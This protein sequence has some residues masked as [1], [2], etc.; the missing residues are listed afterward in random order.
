MLIIKIF[1]LS[2]VAA[3]AAAGFL[4][5]PEKVSA[6]TVAFSYYNGRQ[7]KPA[8]KMPTKKY[9]AKRSKKNRS[10]TDPT[11]ISSEDDVTCRSE[12]QDAKE[13]TTRAIASFVETPS[14]VK[15]PEK[16][17]FVQAATQCELTKRSSIAEQVRGE[18]AEFQLVTRAV[19]ATTVFSD[20]PESKEYVQPTKSF[21][22][23]FAEK[24]STIKPNAA[25]TFLS[26][27]D[28]T[29]TFIKRRPLVA[30][31]S[32]PTMT[33]TG[34]IRYD[35][36]QSPDQQ[37]VLSSASLFN[38]DANTKVVMFD[39]CT[40]F[41][42]DALSE[43]TA[44][45]AEEAA[46]RAAATLG[47]DACNKTSIECDACNKT[48]IVNSLCNDAVAAAEKVCLAN[49]APTPGPP[50][51]S[52]ICQFICGQNKGYLGA[53]T[54]V[55]TNVQ[56]KLSKFL[57]LIN[58]TILANLTQIN[59]DIVEVNTTLANLVTVA[60]TNVEL[61]KVRLE[62]ATEA[63]ANANAAETEAELQANADQAKLEVDKSTE[64]ADQSEES[65]A[66]T[67]EASDATAA[68]TATTAAAA[69][70]GVEAT[71]TALAI[72]ADAIAAAQFGLDPVSDALAVAA[73]AAEGVATGADTAANVAAA[74]ADATETAATSAQAASTTADAAADAATASA[75]AADD[76]AKGE[77]TTDDEA[78][79]KATE[80]ETKCK[81]A[82]T[83]AQTHQNDIQ[84]AANLTA[85]LAMGSARVL[86]ITTEA[87]NYTST[88]LN[89]V[90]N[91]TGYLDDGAN[92]DKNL[93]TAC[94]K[95]EFIYAIISDA[96]G[97]L[98]SKF[99]S[100]FAK[101]VFPLG[102]LAGS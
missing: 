95:G 67:A 43:A 87:V 25:I 72:T 78:I 64:A 47:L 6:T 71:D 89:I 55:T 77:E 46:C 12:L 84:K 76:L 73:D 34:G 68:T 59:N 69:A 36:E 8:S 65:A 1:K 26:D 2:L 24:F 74:T 48:I 27:D 45:I 53:V 86:N 57:N 15:P 50:N 18:K 16:D 22:A 93:C 42:D 7:L 40:L 83:K 3:V 62:A 88:L 21:V 52:S 44:A 31:L 39:D 61:R 54:N 100:T 23:D 19:S 37:G 49:A 33:D 66:A 85:E 29:E 60:N 35:L 51:N 70:D 92:I 41:I 90:K 20:A 79:E 17:L 13:E 32:N 4:Y 94:G 56:S 9:I 81:E 38:N 14:K 75:E 63:L 99:N 10:S 30:I 97:L 91:F 96:L 5:H 102:N 101:T 11:T 82:L 28:D 98:A 80:N 58:N